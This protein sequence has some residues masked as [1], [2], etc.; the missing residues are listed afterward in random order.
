MG[1][2][3]KIEKIVDLPIMRIDTPKLMIQKGHELANKKYLD[4][5]M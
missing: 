3:W 1:D 5:P 2:V 4:V